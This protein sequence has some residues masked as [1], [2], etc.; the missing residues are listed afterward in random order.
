MSL[1]R[2]V[3]AD[4]TRRAIQAGCKPAIGSIAHAPEHFGFLR[5]GVLT[6]RRG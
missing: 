3:S 6:A 1:H 2:D 4:L 5:L